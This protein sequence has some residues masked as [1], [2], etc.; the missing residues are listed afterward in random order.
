ML[1]IGAVIAIVV[2]RSG[3]EDRRVASD[4]A[5]TVVAPGPSQIRRA[6]ELQLRFETG[7]C[8]PGSD[9]DIARQLNA[10]LRVEIQDRPEA[11]VIK[12]RLDHAYVRS[13]S[14][15]ERGDVCAGVGLEFTR[16]IRLPSPIGRRAL[17]NGGFIPE[18]VVPQVIRPS[19]VKGQNA[20]W[21]NRIERLRYMGINREGEP[22]DA[23]ETP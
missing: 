13:I 22:L 7:T 6:T 20:L 18:G 8:H 12:A 21:S 23:G 19:L 5:F 14:P 16:R 9:A 10:P 11:V 2:S 3:G 15:P 17:L 4:E 1:A